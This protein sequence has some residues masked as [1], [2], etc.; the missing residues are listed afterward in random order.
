MN[1]HNQ[2]NL[3]QFFKKRLKDDT[4]AENGWNVPPMS[5]LDNAL[6]AIEPEAIDRKPLI[7]KS[8]LGV[9]LLAVISMIYLV[10]VQVQSLNDELSTLKQ[11]HST[12]LASQPQEEVII[13]SEPLNAETSN[14]TQTHLEVNQKN[15]NNND[16]A[17]YQG[18]IVNLEKTSKSSIASENGFVIANVDQ[19]IEAQENNRLVRNF[20]SSQNNFTSPVT[21]IQPNKISSQLPIVTKPTN[22][23]KIEK[24]L[25][26]TLLP[27]QPSLLSY[28]G[29]ELTM[30]EPA[31]IS[32]DSKREFS[33]YMLSGLALS[34]YQMI[35]AQP[36]EYSLSQYQNYR[37]G[38]Q[39]EV[40]FTADLSDRWN[41]FTSI[42]YA[43]WSNRSMFLQEVTY[44]ESNM[45]IDPYGVRTY[46]DMIYVGS[47]SSVNQNFMEFQFRSEEMVDGAA[48]LNKTII[49]DNYQSIGL[50]LGLSYDIIQQ[51]RFSLSAYLGSTLRSTFSAS[52]NLHTELYD[53]SL[54]MGDNRTEY[55]I[56]NQLTN[57]VISGTIGSQVSYSLTSK[58]N[59]L[60]NV[61]YSRDLSPINLRT[62]STSQ[63][64][65]NRF[66]FGTGL[67]YKL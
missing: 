16:T 15:T 35:G 6:E 55:S 7:W 47:P 32:E 64:Y 40:G 2:H 53:G 3:D 52:Q 43:R 18:T 45:I 57:Q 1:E 48:M 30:I 5:I 23:F 8:L 62:S 38:F 12:I 58:I 24:Q 25:P 19:K 41:V 31:T 13:P 11:Q 42:E 60:F 10:S 9:G 67:A 29:K 27:S 54:M 39:A 59:L 17:K 46:S 56:Q 22:T 37:P 50:S 28:R 20:D 63:T 44:D 36:D 33:I 14:N 66:F 26:I 34:N 51:S 65:Q 49:E 61:D 4:P 21:A